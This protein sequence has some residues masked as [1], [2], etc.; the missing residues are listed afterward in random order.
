LVEWTGLEKKGQSKLNFIVE[1]YLITNSSKSLPFVVKPCP[2]KTLLKKI[3]S[4][5]FFVLPGPNLKIWNLF[6]EYVGAG[7]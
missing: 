7:G 2:K 1:S 4:T 3:Y 6:C 5:F